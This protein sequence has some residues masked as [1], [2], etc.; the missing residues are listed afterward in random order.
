MKKIILFSSIA[1]GLL[2]IA[3]LAFFLINGKKKPIVYPQDTI[4]NTAG[5]LNNQ[6]LFCERNGKVYFSRPGDNDYLYSMDINEENMQKLV[7]VPVRNLLC[8]G[9]HIY[10]TQ[11]TTD[12][13]DGGLGYVRSRHSLNR[14]NLNGKDIQ[15]LNYDIIIQAQL[16]GSQLYLLTTKEDNI[17]FS[18]YN[19]MNKEEVQLADYAVNP[20]C[21]LAPYIYFSDTIDDHS[22]MRLDTTNDTIQTLC[23]ES[24]WNPVIY[25][26]SI[27]YMDVKR[28]YRLCRY[29]LAENSVQILTEDRVDC[30]N[31]GND[32]IYYQ[33]CDVKAPC[34]KMMNT[35]G[36]DVQTLATG[37]YTNINMTSMYVYFQE[38]GVDGTLYHSRIGSLE[39]ELFP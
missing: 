19:V 3:V 21:A 16:V 23:K 25:N 24:F 29:R 37:V 13:S 9:E 4:G 10:Y 36:K 27:Y 8:S 17:S 15:T 26:G 5:N 32:Y 12:T 39:Y 14:C 30:F 11:L 38:F 34:L 20:S 2:L 22:L 18:K 1:G 35:D 33:T 7:A 6:G 31:V 28:D